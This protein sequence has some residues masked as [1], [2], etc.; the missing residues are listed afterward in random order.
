MAGTLETG[1]QSWQ[2]SV[3]LTLSTGGSQDLMDTP[4]TGKKLVIQT[5]APSIPI[6]GTAA[7][8][9]EFRFVTPTGS[10]TIWKINSGSTKQGVV[11]LFTQQ[12]RGNQGFDLP[13]NAKI[14]AVP[15]SSGQTTVLSFIGMGAITSP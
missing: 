5:F 4:G 14:V 1:T 11:P 12:T 8:T 6:A 13:E 10:G 2:T 7:S 3:E 9:V 15:D